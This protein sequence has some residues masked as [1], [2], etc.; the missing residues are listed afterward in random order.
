M[1]IITT[2][3]T[4]S[5]DVSR[6]LGA[7]SPA[8]RAGARCSSVWTVVTAIALLRVWGCYTIAHEGRIAND[9]SG[10]GPW[11]WGT[12]M[13][14]QRVGSVAPDQRGDA[15]AP[16]SAHGDLCAVP[17]DQQGAARFLLA[18]LAH[19]IDAYDRGAVHTYEMRRIEPL[20]QRTERFAEEVSL[21]Q[22]VH[23]RVVVFGLDPVDLRRVEHEITRASGHHDRGRACGRTRCVRGFARRA[24]KIHEL[25]GEVDRV[26]GAEFV[27]HALQRTVEAFLA[28]RFQQV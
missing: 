24:Q 27:L 18:E 2:P 19:A 5:I 20:L 28:H 13:S 3:R 17:Q 11:Q 25:L 1:R 26:V 14:V 22:R 6:P 21:P 15:L 23:G 9:H 10:C 7:R 16:A 12:A 4:M 8:S